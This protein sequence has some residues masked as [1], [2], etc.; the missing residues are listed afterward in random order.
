MVT[1]LTEGTTNVRAARRK[2]L[3]TRGHTAEPD[4]APQPGCPLL[5]TGRASAYCTASVVLDRIN[6]D[7]LPIDSFTVPG[8]TVHACVPSSQ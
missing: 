5:V 2:L 6:A 4:R 8:S 7:E 3:K 1:L